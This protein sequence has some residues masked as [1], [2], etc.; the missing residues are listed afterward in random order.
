MP[1]IAKTNF[2]LGQISFQEPRLSKNQLFP[3]KKLVFSRKTNFA[4]GK[5]KK[6]PFSGAIIVPTKIVVF[7][8]LVLV[9]LGFLYFHTLLNKEIILARIQVETRNP[10]VQ[11]SNIEF[12]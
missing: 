10:K 3:R 7:G 2:F 5:P 9:L 8:F 12:N 4:L 6:I 11:N 1:R